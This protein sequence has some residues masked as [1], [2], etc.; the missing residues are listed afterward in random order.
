VISHW[1]DVEYVRRDRGHIGGAWASLTGS[2]SVTVGVKRI[3]VDPGKWSTPAHVEGSE[4]EIFYVLGGS[5][6]SWQDGNCHAVAAG[7]F[8]LHRAG[9][10][11]HT[12]RADD[13]GLDVLAFGQRHSVSS[14]Y[15]PRAGASWLGPSW[16]R[17]GSPEDHPWARE[18]AA[19]P[20]EV[21]ELGPRSANVVNVD[22]VGSHPADAEPGQ[23]TVRDAGT[24]L[25]S[26]QTG[27]KHV[28]LAPGDNGAPPTL[29]RPRRRS[30]S[31]SQEA[32]SSSSRRR[33]PR[34]PTR[35]WARSP[36]ARARRWR[37][38]QA[39]ESRTASAPARTG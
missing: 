17:S 36:S 10:E 19:G 16:T 9:W 33:R 11:A 30:S 35:S 24:A 28:T 6:I 31:S 22:D 7:D 21:A 23:S 38:P 34:F 26:I 20:P 27:V 4:E 18:A 1:D 2:S 37:D 8:L 3:R 39:P 15:L 5:G 32:V 29:T 14:A 13:D 25:G 12:L